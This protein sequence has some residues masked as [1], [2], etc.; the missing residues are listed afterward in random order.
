MTRDEF[1]I[2]KIKSEYDETERIIYKKESRVEMFNRKTQKNEVYNIKYPENNDMIITTPEELTQDINHINS[3]TITVIDKAI[4]KK[5]N[6][7]IR[8][9]IYETVWRIL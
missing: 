3:V 7:L 8:E 6:T 2:M 9:D 5:D 1:A 4:D